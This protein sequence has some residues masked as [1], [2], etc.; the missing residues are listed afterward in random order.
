MFRCYYFVDHNLR[1]KASAKIRVL[2][3]IWR[4]ETT[5][6]HY[7]KSVLSL[8][9]IWWLNVT[10]SISLKKVTISVDCILFEVL[11]L[12]IIVLNCPIH[13]FGDTVP[14]FYIFFF[15]DMIWGENFMQSLLV[16]SICFL[17]KKVITFKT[18]L[19]WVFL[20]WLVTIQSKVTH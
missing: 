4:C 15:F 10:P 20:I 2:I 7:L 19:I 17:I 14:D 3:L 8:F 16:F 6:V 18:V 9:N 1:V 5:D 12:P 13:N 11:F